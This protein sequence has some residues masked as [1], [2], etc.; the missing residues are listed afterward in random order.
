[1]NEEAS[2]KPDE[3][4]CE[5][6]GS[7][8]AADMF[9]SEK[10]SS[11]PCNYHYAFDIFNL[12]RILANMP[13]S[14]ASC[15]SRDIFT[16]EDGIEDA[17]GTANEAHRVDDAKGMRLMASEG[18][19]IRDVMGAANEAYP[20]IAP[21]DDEE[22]VREE[23]RNREDACG[24]EE[25]KSVNEG[26]T[27]ANEGEKAPR[28]AVLWHG[29]DDGGNIFQ[30]FSKTYATFADA[31]ETAL[32]DYA[33]AKRGVALDDEESWLEYKRGNALELNLLELNLSR[34]MKESYEEGG[35]YGEIVILPVD[36]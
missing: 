3:I 27:K 10:A 5:H 7:L 9:I 19:N 12:D 8:A 14:A 15:T 32:R 2:G 29:V 20:A 35:E 17:P 23:V 36:T 26:E 34:C 33:F 31:L 28:Y 24:K 4:S 18:D 30:H 16:T 1:M 6:I 21:D 13:S 22:A 25:E 11:L